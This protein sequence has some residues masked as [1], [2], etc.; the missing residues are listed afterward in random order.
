VLYE[1]NGNRGVQATS[2]RWLRAHEPV[3]H[4]DAVGW[5]YNEPRAPVGIIPLANCTSEGTPHEL[6][7]GGVLARLQ[8][9]HL[10]RPGEPYYFAYI[11]RFNSDQPC[12]PTVLY[13]VRGKEMRNLTV[14]LQFDTRAMPLQIC[15][16]D[17]GAQDSGWEWP[18]DGAPQWLE[19]APNGFIQH[20]FEVC[21]QGRQY[22]LKWKWPTGL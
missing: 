20:S 10:L 7:R 18:E 16:F 8:F 5:Y 3:D 11:T 22:G 2:H 6:P 13:E 4:Y 17:L 19:V 1:F 21:L 12:M 15:Y 9:S 14:S